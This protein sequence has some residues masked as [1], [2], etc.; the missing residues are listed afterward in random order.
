MNNSEKRLKR[1][2]TSSKKNTRNPQYNESLS[3]NIPKSSLCDTILEIEAIHEYGTFGMG[4]KVLGRLELP[5][6]QVHELWKAIIREEKSQARWYP[7]E[8]PRSL[9]Y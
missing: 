1:K 9:H 2:K 6:H 4:C 5:L 3:F 7:L 8:H